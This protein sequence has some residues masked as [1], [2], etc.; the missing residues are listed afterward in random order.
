MIIAD[1]DIASGHP[2]IDL[3]LAERYHSVRG[4][5]SR[6][7]AAIC[8][9]LI[10]RQTH[11]GISGC[12]MEIGTFEGR[13]FIAMALGLAAGETALGIDR[14]DWPD[15]GVEERFHANCAANG[16]TR[17]RYV[18]WKADSRL[19][20]P[21]GLREK[22]G[23]LPVRFVHIDSHHSRDCLTNDLE[24][25]TPLMHRDGIVCLDDMLH[26]GYPMVVSAVLDYFARHREMRL[27]C[28]IDRE[29]IVA[30]PKFLICREEARMGY[31]QDLLQAF[32]RFH[33]ILNADMETY[34]AL[35]LTPH[36]RL[37][38]VGT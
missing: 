15:A 6:F 20:T 22:S 31:E 27:L 34:F 35:V 33:F 37:A 26:P 30:A 12:V 17:D 18:A 19:I 2:A 36:P 29:D 11:C 14:F 9:H 21:G 10:S 13:F 3:Y 38:E 7:A 1:R 32:S 25:V 5:S 16:I 24:L 4:M 28:V 23:G 8:G